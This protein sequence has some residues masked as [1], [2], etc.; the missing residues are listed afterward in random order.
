MENQT[1]K[2]ASIGEMY[3][4]YLGVKMPNDQFHQQLYSDEWHINTVCGR[5]CWRIIVSAF[6]L[7]DASDSSVHHE[8]VAAALH[9]IEVVCFG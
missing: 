5:H 2:H 3:E 7:K 6:L 4:Q 9:A 1:A 8:I